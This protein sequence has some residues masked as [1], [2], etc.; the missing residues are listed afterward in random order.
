MVPI[1]HPSCQRKLAILVET[2]Y[3]LAYEI[4]QQASFSKTDLT[5]WLSKAVRLHDANVDEL[6]QADKE[7][8]SF[9]LRDS[10]YSKSNVRNLLDELL[11][12]DAHL[13]RCCLT[14]VDL[15]RSIDHLA[16]EDLES[17]TGSWDQGGIDSAV[18][19]TIEVLYECEFRR[20]I[21]LR[22][23][24]LSSD[25]LPLQIP[26]FHAD[27]IRLG[28]NDIALLLGERS[29]YSVLHGP[30]TGDCFLAF[31]ITEPG[32]DIEAFGVAWSKAHEILSVLKY[33]KY[34]AIDIDYG[35]I[36]YAPEWV[37]DIRRPGLGFWGQPRRD[38]QSAFYELT[39]QDIPRLTDFLSAYMK[40]KGIL[41]DPH[42][43]S[44]R[45]ANALAS[46]YYQWHYRKAE[47]ER[48]QKL[49]E[50]VTALEA[51]FSPNKGGE[52][53]F[54]ISQRAAI[55]LGKE[56]DDR[57]CLWK[58]FK[59]L[60]D[61]RSQIL[62]SGISAFDPPALLT[63]KD[64]KDLTIVSNEDL[65]QLGD[66][67][68]QALLKTL[69]LVWREKGNKDDLNS[70]LDRAALDESIRKELFEQSDLELALQEILQSPTG[71]HERRPS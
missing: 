70:M 65:S 27:L 71:T 52:L 2:K 57:L 51:L 14:A 8:R 17:A 32:E 47:T 13:R 15:A 66:L 7:L 63:E 61:A 42:P 48:D 3:R 6:S 31:S 21:F 10:S 43:K 50:L 5:W 29:S 33:V 4:R 30:N 23:Y 59:R 54:R 12:D 60:Y 68:R 22:I 16:P 67:V 9:I 62:H 53:R 44:L 26:T 36:Y 69:I 41:D 19:Q 64:K 56:A 24:N 37:N 40:L 18:H 38:K 28:Q 49:V 25:C 39:N 1:P 45:L 46:H 20:N 34:G 11:N 58:F 35:A 55:F